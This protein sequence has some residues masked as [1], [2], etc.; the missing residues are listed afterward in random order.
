MHSNVPAGVI[1]LTDKLVQRNCPPGCVATHPEYGMVSVLAANALQREVQFTISR[2]PVPIP[3]DTPDDVLYMEE[4][5]VGTTWVHVSTLEMRSPVRDLELLHPKDWS[6]IAESME[7][8]A[9]KRER[10]ERLEGLEGLDFS[11]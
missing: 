9:A 3:D 5:E 8:R 11:G 2:Q 6:A 4:I 1:S 7:A 10:R